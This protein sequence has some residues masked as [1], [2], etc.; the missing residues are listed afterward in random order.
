MSGTDAVREDR[1]SSRVPPR[2]SVLRWR[3][4]GVTYVAANVGQVEHGRIAATWRITGSDDLHNWDVVRSRVGNNPAALASDWVEVPTLDVVDFGDV[5]VANYVESLA[6]ATKG[7]DRRPGT[8][9]QDNAGR[10]V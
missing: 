2:G 6:S 3:H 4:Q 5:D 7:R 8:F 10:P 9:S 1:F